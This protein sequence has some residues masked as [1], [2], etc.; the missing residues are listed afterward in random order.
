M[1]T[2]SLPAVLRKCMGEKFGEFDQ[3]QLGKHGK[4]MKKNKI[5]IIDFFGSKAENWEE[6]EMMIEGDGNDDMSDVSESLP[7]LDLAQKRFSVKRLIRLLHIKD[8]V[9]HVMAILEKK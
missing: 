4:K 1:I 3:Y 6:A 7:S 2:G 9:F 5:P 8:P